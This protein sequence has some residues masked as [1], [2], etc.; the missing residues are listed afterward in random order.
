MVKSP[1][2]CIFAT[3][4]WGGCVCPA[5]AVVLGQLSGRYPTAR[6]H[7][8]AHYPLSKSIAVQVPNR[9]QLPE[10]GTALVPALMLPGSSPLL[11]HRLQPDCQRVFVFSSRATF[12]TCTEVLAPLHAFLAY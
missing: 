1:E 11:A 5:G 10:V 3:P 6:A 12:F 7:L 8:L 9:I 2:S 4:E